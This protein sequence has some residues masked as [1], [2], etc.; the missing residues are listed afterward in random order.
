MIKN[1]FFLNRFVTE[2]NSLMQGSLV[3]S[4]FS[5]EK[6]KLII[7]LKKNNV[8]SF[9]EISANPGFPYITLKDKFNRAKKNT[10]GFF[11]KCTSA[12]LISFGISD[13]DRIIKINL[14][15][16]NLYFAIRG[17]YTNVSFVTPDSSIEHFKNPPD[18]FIEDNFLNE[19]KS[20]NFINEFNN[21]KIELNTGKDIWE[22]LKT[23]YP[24][25]GKEILTEAKSRASN[26]NTQEITLIVAKIVNEIFYEKPVVFLD[27][28]N[29]T[30]HLAPATFKI[31]HFTERIYFDDII[32]AFN[33][34]IGKKYYLDTLAVKKKKIQKHLEKELTRLSSKL[35]KLKGVIERGSKEEEYKKL[36][37]LLLINISSLRK[38][39]K[40]IE[41]QDIYN[42]N[43]TVK[44]KLNDT[45]P[46][47]KNVDLYFDKAKSDRTRYEKSVQLFNEVS[48]LY[49]LQKKYEQKLFTA[50]KLEEF[51]LIM[52]ELKI[53]EDNGNKNDVDIKSK[54][55]HYIIDNKFNVYVGKDSRNNDLLTTKFAKQN[56]FWFHAR[57][58]PGS[59]VVL[60]VENTKE[61]VP[62]SILKKAAS[63]AAFHSKAKTAGT[64]PVSFTL[65]KYV[66][67]KKGMEAGMVAL[68][69]EDVLLVSPE[70]PKNC[71]YVLND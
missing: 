65:K 25:L 41:V 45:L 6:D 26:E 51:N 23:N 22:Q 57:S 66:V 20:T 38:G 61:I 24:F 2:V 71:E 8:Y 49:S 64:V 50:E 54:F 5:Q 42:E 16:G 44:I 46:P 27:N 1:Y 28:N 43:N 37:N 4:V 34:Y 31:F 15:C 11:S 58:V 55:K 63:L 35:N 62:K 40:I 59:H 48:E 7:E 13:S 9:L 33:F 30:L 12:E 47:K 19:I 60:R 21:F 36:G 18:D 67:K 52:K 39:M 56:D 3:S 14:S 32:S 70:I 29:F 69:R 53:K 10:I 68:L 17:K